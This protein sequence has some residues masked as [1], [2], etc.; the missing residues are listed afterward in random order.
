[1][2]Q[3]KQYVKSLMQISRVKFFY[4]LPRWFEVATPLGG[5]NPDWAVVVKDSRKLYLIRETKSTF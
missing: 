4:K 1:M 2:S 3:A 5:Y